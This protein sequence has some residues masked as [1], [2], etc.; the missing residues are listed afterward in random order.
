MLQPAFFLGHA[1]T[2]KT[3]EL[4]GA[5]RESTGKLLLD[6]QQ[7]VLALS[8]MHGAIRR[9]EEKMREDCREVPTV[10][11]TIDSFALTVVNRW[12][13]AMGHSRP[14]V[15][16]S[17]DSSFEGPFQSHLTFTRICEEAAI[18]IASST[19]GQLIGFS[20]PIVVIDEFQDCHGAKL[21]LV[22]QLAKHCQ[23]FAAADDFQLLEDGVEGCPSVNWIREAHELG[24]RVVTLTKP[25]RCSIAA[26]VK[27]SVALRTNTRSLQTTISVYCC[28]VIVMAATKL[29]FHRP[30]GD[31][32]LISP[33]HR[34]ITNILR[35]HDDWLR[36]KGR[37]PV[38]WRREAS[39]QEETTGL[40]KEM[41][42]NRARKVWRVPNAP[43]SPTA[44][45]AAH[46]I[47]KASK[48]RGLSEI[49]MSFAVSLAQRFMSTRALWHHR[50]VKRMALTVHG[51]KNREFDNVV[52]FWSPHSVKGWSEEMRRRL[53][54][55]AVTRAK[56]TCVVLYLGD[57]QSCLDD[58]VV[59][60]LGSAE[61]AFGP[62]K[63]SKRAT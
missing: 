10:I 30:G 21:D 33:T 59:G 24:A 61:P 60:L 32:A 12:R 41:A 13:G 15:P 16:T 53:L 31:F 28:P 44:L 56:R 49:P 20:Y 36:R 25:H 22:K 39:K 43:L 54:Y 45:R 4:M 19:V 18:L 57:E 29:T 62:P 50:A 5:T 38:Y 58:P 46:F 51:A 3:K 37:V 7:R 2:G 26:I 9:L 6:K 34:D 52:I 35:A 14:I 23:L 40:M 27:A 48:L 42:L 8:V 55:N 1:G 11:R 63:R 17:E 47:V